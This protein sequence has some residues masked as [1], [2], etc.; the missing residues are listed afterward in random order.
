MNPD[1]KVRPLKARVCEDTETIFT[2]DFWDS[3]LLIINAVDN[4]KA[5]QYIDKKS[6]IH[7]K[8]L[9][10]AGTLGTQC[11]SQLIL[12]GLTECYNDSQ[13][14]PE[15]SIPMCTLKNFPHLIEHTIEWSKGKF[16]NLFVN[17]SQFLVEYRKDQNKTLNDLEYKLK[18]STADVKT[19]I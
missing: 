4:I 17:V 11:N 5:R 9:F 10:E 12:P 16:E 14:P 1:F 2:D 3:Q 6:V 7:T 19:L 13:D 8:S 15:K 18:N